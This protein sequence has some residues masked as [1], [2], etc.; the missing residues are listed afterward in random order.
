MPASSV[1]TEATGIVG[2][3]RNSFINAMRE[4]IMP[5]WNDHINYGTKLAS[6]IMKKKGTLDGTV[7]L[8]NVMNVAPA[9]AGVSV[10]E[11][12]TW[13][14]PTTSAYFNPRIISRYLTARLRWTVQV[15][16]AARGG[17]GAVWK[18]PRRVEME[19]AKKVMGLNVERM[20]FTGVFQPLGVAKSNSAGVVTLYNREGRTSVIGDR[21]E[22]G[23]Q[24]MR[25]GQQVSHL[26]AA[27]AGTP[28]P[29]AA[30]ANTAQVRFITAIDTTGADP[31]ITLAAT[32]GGA[33]AD[34]TTASADGDL[35]V[36]ALS[37]VA[38]G[39]STD[40]AAADSLASGIN[41]LDN[42]IVNSSYKA[43]VYGLSRTTVPSLNGFVFDNG[44][45]GTRAWDERYISLSVDK[46]ADDGTGD[47][48]DTIVLHS[49]VRREYVKETQGDR[50]FEPVLQKKGFKALSFSAGD[51]L[52]PLVTTKDCPPGCAYILDTTSFGWF[53]ESELGM[54]D[55]GDRFIADQAA[56]EVMLMKSGNEACVK[57]HNNAV[58]M[59][60]SYSTT[61]LTA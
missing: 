56:H 27:S 17:K 46:I 34:F 40:G 4:K 42:L 50:R 8:G 16:K 30:V 11:G 6:K 23:A 29:A 47:D 35:L 10:F 25:V 7:S 38:A 48:P 22:F 20:L 28:D 45:S 53:S 52:L 1:L 24:F 18:A 60:L 57:P 58:V 33:A 43:Y 54:I 61:G 21:Y 39:I 14:S 55:D 37:R 36:P 15:E 49:S 44:S 59:D 2:T 51:T 32:E 26:L 19:A 3:S 5:A 41:G 9:N 12:S 31:T 13:G